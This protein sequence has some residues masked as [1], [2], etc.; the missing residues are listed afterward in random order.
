MSDIAD[1]PKH[2]SKRGLLWHLKWLFA[3]SAASF[4]LSL[5]A[6]LVSLPFAGFALVEWWFKPQGSLVMFL[7]A[8]AVSPLIY[9]RLR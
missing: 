8:V 2:G 6:I 1:V 7:L 5:L 4:G 3:C 9:R